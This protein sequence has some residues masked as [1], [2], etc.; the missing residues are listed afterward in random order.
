MRLANGGHPYEMAI[1]G[2][3]GVDF[4]VVGLGLGALALL[5]G[6]CLFGWAGR[7]ERDAN[8]ATTR[9]DAV[10]FSAMATWRRDAGQALLGAGSAILLAT[11]GA[12]AGSLTDQTGAFLVTTTATVAALGLLLWAYLYRSRHPI[13]PRA[14]RLS[15]TETTPVAPADTPERVARPSAPATMIGPALPA[16]MVHMDASTSSAAVEPTSAPPPL[17]DAV[18]AS[19]HDHAPDQAE[20][21]GEPGTGTGPAAEQAPAADVENAAPNADASTDSEPASHDAGPAR[22]L[23]DLVAYSTGPTTPR[24]PPDDE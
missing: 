14:A 19:D 20:D 5:G 6:V 8:R 17:L 1:V 9:Q 15:G 21:V 10:H 16:S 23:A 3:R 18:T 12:L 22:G 13:P 4:V 7:W 24:I 2:R 11:I